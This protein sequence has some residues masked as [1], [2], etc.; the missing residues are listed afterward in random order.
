MDDPRHVIDR[1]TLEMLVCPLTKTRLMLS[2]AGDELI[3]VAAHLAFPIRAG[4]PLLAAARVTSS[5]AQWA[6]TDRSMPA[7][8]ARSSGA[9]GVYSQVSSGAVIPARRSV[10]ASV[11]WATPSQAAPPSTAARDTGTRPWP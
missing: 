11:S 9:P 3:S 7:A 4:V 2:P 6:D 5:R 10:S 8:T 1:K